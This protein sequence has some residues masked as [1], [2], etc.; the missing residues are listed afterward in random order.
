MEKIPEVFNFDEFQLIN[1]FFMVHTF[2]VISKKSS[3]Y[4]RL[5]RFSPIYLLGVLQF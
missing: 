3:P 2:G 4:P 5:S 1:H